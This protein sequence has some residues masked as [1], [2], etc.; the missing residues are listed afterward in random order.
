MILLIKSRNR[1][2]YS[3]RRE[4]LAKVSDRFFVYFLILKLVG[5]FYQL[6]HIQIKFKSV[7]TL[8]EPTIILVSGWVVKVPEFSTVSN[9]SI[10]PISLL[11]RAWGTCG[12]C[13]MPRSACGCARYFDSGELTF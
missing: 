10:S 12:T 3:E 5:L 13:H 11:C 8:R 2:F 1:S 9:H 7:A 6:F 4:T